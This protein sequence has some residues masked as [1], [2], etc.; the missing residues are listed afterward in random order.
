MMEARIV[1]RRSRRLW[2]WSGLG[3]LVVVGVIAGV[4]VV[5]NARGNG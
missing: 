4:L 3:V 1:T 5:R 2:F